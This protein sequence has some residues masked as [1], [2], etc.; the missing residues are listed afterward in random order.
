MVGDWGV[1]WGGGGGKG[2]RSGVR[3]KMEERRVGWT[4]WDGLDSCI[5]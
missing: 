3:G 1:D 4:C 2:E 5:E